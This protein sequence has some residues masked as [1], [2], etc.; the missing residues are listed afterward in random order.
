MPENLWKGMRPPLVTSL[1][2]TRGEDGSVNASPKSWW[3]PVSYEP[4][5]VMLSV[6]PGSDTDR[7]I[8]ES[9][10]F[11][12]HLPG[13]MQA[14]QVL[15]TAKPLP[16]G[17]NELDDQK[18]EWEWLEENGLPV[19][20]YVPWMPWL[21][22]GVVSRMDAQQ[23]L[24][25]HTLYLAKVARAGGFEKGSGVTDVLLHRGRNEFVMAG[26]TYQVEPY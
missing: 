26:D 5:V 24:S 7:N 14:Q 10:L 12:L 18:I 6:K 17:E 19:V 20:P 9:G 1:V 2:A 15:H 16:Y 23:G 3:T 22:C 11:V 25:D 13:T 8:R 21:Y 4:P